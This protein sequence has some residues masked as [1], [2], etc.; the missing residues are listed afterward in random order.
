L[1]K[2]KGRSARPFPKDAT[3]PAQ[4]FQLSVGKNTHFLNHAF[5]MSGY[6]VFEKGSPFFGQMHDDIAP[7]FGVSLTANKFSLLKVIYD[8]GDIALALEDFTR[9]ISLAEGAV[10]VQDLEYGKL[11]EA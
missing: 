11:T 1:Q 6:N 10:M 2:E 4:F 7:V 8:H 5:D 3:Q 9:D